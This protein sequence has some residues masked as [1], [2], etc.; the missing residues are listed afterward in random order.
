VVI[1][2]WNGD[3][4]ESDD[5]TM[6]TINSNTNRPYVIVLGNEKGGTGKSTVSMH[7]IAHL[8]RLGFKVASMDLDA[9]QGTL[10]RY[11]ENRK[12]Y[13]ETKNVTLP[14]PT[15]MT[16]H[17]S[18]K[19]NIKEA[20]QEEAAALEAAMQECANFNFVVID[21][22]GND[23]HL[24]REAHARAD[25]LITPMNDSFVDLDVLM[26]IKDIRKNELRPSTYAETIWNQKKV[27]LMRDK[28][29]M[30]WIVLRNRLSNLNATNKKEMWKILNLLSG[31]LGYRLAEGFGERVIFR[32][33]FLHG[34]TLLDLKDLGMP[35]QISHVA[36]R[37][38]LRSLIQM[39]KLPALEE[40]LKEVI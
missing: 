25:T 39:I 24:S 17:R 2:V 7:I 15:H 36:A 20:E 19:E 11:I 37:Q 16:L 1:S 40:R 32:E 22:P 13:C 4:I 30:D 34:L 5:K 31:R 8:L 6:T 10:S 3:L 28:V 38:E 33:L 14:I 12:H 23:T 29:S 35:M 27:R 9:R 18:L 26:Q 21:T